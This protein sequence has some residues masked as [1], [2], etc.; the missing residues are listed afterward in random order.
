MTKGTNPMPTA[1]K[2]A[3]LVEALIEAGS[4]GG[5]WMGWFAKGHHQPYDFAWAVNNGHGLDDAHTQYVRSESVKH[6]WWRKVPIAGDP[7][8]YRFVKAEQGARGAFPVTVADIL[9]DRMKQQQKGYD[10][11]KNHGVREGVNW[12]YRWLANRDMKMADQMLED[13]R[14]A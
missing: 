7:G 2:Q 14:Q 4:D 10:Q 8:Q 13:W 9:N 1:T 6:E 5:G 11:A 12:A 3:I